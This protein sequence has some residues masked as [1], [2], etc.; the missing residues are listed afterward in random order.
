MSVKL[1][2]AVGAGISLLGFATGSPR[3]LYGQGEPSGC[4]AASAAALRGDVNQY[5][6][7]LLATCPASGPAALA[8]IWVQPGALTP[9]ELET[10]VI[11]SA[12]L[13]DGRLYQTVMSVVDSAGPSNIR[14]AALRVLYSY[15]FPDLL[16]SVEEL[17]R[18]RVGVM[19]LGMIQSWRPGWERRSQPTIPLP[20]ERFGQ[21][22]ALLARLARQDPDPE[23]Q[24]A[25]M[26]LRQDLAFR[27]PEHTPVR[28]DAI[29]V[30]AGC[31]A[32]VNLQSIEDVTLQVRVRVLETTFDHTLSMKGNWGDPTAKWPLFLPPG[33][34]VVTY[35]SRELARLT[36][37]NGP[38]P[39]G[40]S[41]PYRPPQT[42]E[43]QAK[44]PEHC[45]R[46]ETM[47]A[48]RQNYALATSE[49]ISC[50]STGPRAL[51]REWANPP[52][53]SATLSKLGTASSFL[54][55]RRLL[56]VVKAVASSASQT[57]AVR[58]EAI[59]TLVSYF[60]PFILVIV[61]VRPWIQSP[62]SIY[63]GFGGWTEPR[64]ENGSEP[65][66]PSTK[67]EVLEVL[68]QLRGADDPVLAKVAKDILAQ[69]RRG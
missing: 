55:D 51:A 23:V 19:S 27:D 22:G 21:V 43:A 9:P 49:L 68:E 61:G 17:K 36:E 15:Y 24:W 40:V 26:H 13:Q 48:A 38:C 6:I 66:P 63:V 47:L 18:S 33:T 59:R 11:A 53:D 45:A 52:V 10:L 16:P 7:G 60:D 25:A 57:R 5:R 8:A 20:E 29:I 67:T 28:P 39:P 2:L 3:A 44:E 54:R 64:G 30:E 1:W 46:A 42:P 4:A 32:G 69:L 58:L 65:L 14:L 31:G 56:A 62:D 50:P 41:R 37:R 35:G 12:I 34:V